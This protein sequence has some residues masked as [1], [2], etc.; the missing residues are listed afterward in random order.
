VLV[1]API[2][3]RRRL[4]A[5]AGFAAHWAEGAQL[6]ERVAAHSGP[7][8]PDVLVDTT[9]RAAVLPTALDLAGH[10]GRVAVVGLTSATA[11]SSPGPIP[12]KELDVLGV[13]C[14]LRDEFASAA[15]LVA[16]HPALIDSLVSHV[17]PLDE[18]AGA[19]QLL[20][21]RP[22][23]AFKVLVDVAG[24]TRLPTDPGDAR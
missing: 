19:L 20:D 10:G 6:A 21:E 23:E 13:S 11:P 3:A 24:D 5:R 8:G 14:C 16:R 15:D 7:D 18:V 4:L 1:I 12:F 22:A 9:G 2:G 17:F